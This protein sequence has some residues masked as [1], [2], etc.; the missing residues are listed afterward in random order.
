MIGF[1]RG[2]TENET[3]R[4][5]TPLCN[6]MKHTHTTCS[7]D[8]PNSYKL[9]HL[10]F[11]HLPK[12]FPSHDGLVITSCSEQWTPL[13]EELTNPTNPSGFLKF[14]KT[15]RQKDRQKDT[16]RQKDR[17]TERQKEQQRKY[18]RDLYNHEEDGEN[19]QESIFPLSPPTKLRK[20]SNTVHRIIEW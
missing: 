14:D 16:D 1:S 7:S 3:Q 12:P 11:S 18:F 6:N 10:L 5:I 15:E 13:K 2:G 8:P 9:S 20:T 19:E 4:F 17:K